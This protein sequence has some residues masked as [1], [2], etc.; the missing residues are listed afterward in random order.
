MQAVCRIWVLLESE[1]WPEMKTSD[2]DFQIFRFA[3]I[4]RVRQIRNCWHWISLISEEFFLSA[5]SGF[6][7]SYSLFTK[8]PSSVLPAVGTTLR[9][10][11]S[12]RPHSRIKRFSRI[13]PVMERPGTVR[14]AGLWITLLI[15]QN[16]TGNWRTE[17]ES[18][19]SGTKRRKKRAPWDLVYHLD[20]NSLS[21]FS[22]LILFVVNVFLS[23]G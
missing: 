19:F 6:S 2:R 1:I 18:L 10:H 13:V 23:T 11:S 12:H 3:S 21:L 4:K 8:L 15:A 14:P 20:I 7:S 16:Y 9:D 22:L 17:I 5:T